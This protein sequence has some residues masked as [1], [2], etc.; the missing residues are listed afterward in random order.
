[1]RHCRSFATFALRRARVCQ[2]S[3]PFVA[4]P[5]CRAMAQFG[6]AEA[7]AIDRKG[8]LLVDE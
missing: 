3:S 2:G 5:L 7:H 6:T 8:I 1:M 4:Q